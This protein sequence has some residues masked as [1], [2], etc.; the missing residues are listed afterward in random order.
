MFW[1]LRK[2]IRRKS[3]TTMRGARLQSMDF[4][5]FS[6]FSLDLDGRCLGGVRNLSLTVCVSVRILRQ[7]TKRLPN[8]VFMQSPRLLMLQIARQKLE[9]KSAI[10][11]DVP[12]RNPRST[13]STELLLSFVMRCRIIVAFVLSCIA[14]SVS[15]APVPNLSKGLHILNREPENAGVARAPEPD[16]GCKMYLCI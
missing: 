9:K 1:I 5:I 16:P 10:Q 12:K 3:E 8:K 6:D 11:R 2:R 14:L 4:D 7:R 13:I 15:A